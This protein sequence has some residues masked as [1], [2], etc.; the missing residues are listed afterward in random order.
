MVRCGSQRLELSTQ[1]A[2]DIGRVP[3]R[4][5]AL[6]RTTHQ[7]RAHLVARH[8]RDDADRWRERRRAAATA[9]ELALVDR[10]ATT[11]ERD[12]AAIEAEQARQLAAK[13]HVR[14]RDLL[15]L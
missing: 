11:D 12:R 1:P 9:I 5:A 10:G 7:R 8:V 13:E 4:E 14:E 6:R 2:I 15:D 3:P